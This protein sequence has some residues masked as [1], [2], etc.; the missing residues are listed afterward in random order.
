MAT[1]ISCLYIS[2]TYA[3][4]SDFVGYFATSAAHDSRSCECEEPK[5]NVSVA[6]GLGL[7]SRKAKVS[8]DSPTGIT[9]PFFRSLLPSFCR[10]ASGG[11]D[12]YFYLAYDYDDQYFQESEFRDRFAAAFCCYCR[13]HCPTNSTY[14]LRFLL[15]P[16]SRRPAWAQNDAMLEAYLD[17]A[18]YFY[19]VN[20]DTVMETPD[21]TEIFIGTLAAYRPPYV[22]VVG[23]KHRGDSRVLLTYDFVHRTHIDILGFYYPRK[24]PEWYADSWISVVYGP[25]RTTVSEGVRVKHTMEYGQRYKH[26]G[27]PKEERLT[28]R[29][30]ANATIARSAL[31]TTLYLR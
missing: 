12:Y 3:P 4:A 21:W 23:P 1:N 10:T 31:Q 6:V 15:C 28:Q 22:G 9:L 18:D 30:L 19:R 20:D 11:Y 8:E 24:F 2:L 25:G 26:R 13:T 7:T 16:Y 29:E 27:L 17:G 14:T 5:F